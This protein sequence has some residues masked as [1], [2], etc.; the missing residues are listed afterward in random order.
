MRS[1]RLLVTLLAFAAAGVAQAQPVI[2]AD[3]GDSAW[4]LASIVLVLIGAL[5]GFAMI[6]NRGSG[7]APLA[8]LVAMAGA[9][10]LFT[11]FGYSLAFA[12]GSSMIGGA[13]NLLL[14]N[15]ADLRG[16]LT[17]SET[18][19][20]L[21]ELAAAL[22]AVAVL[23]AALAER[24]RF[25]WLACFAS[26][27]FVLVYV[28]LAHWLW[29]GGWLVDL[30]A[31]DAA[32]GLVIHT[33]AG[34][35]ALVAAI[36]LGRRDDDTLVADHRLAL[37][38]I[39][40]VFAGGVGLIGGS[41]LSSSDEAASAMLNAVVAVSAALLVGLGLER[42]RTGTTS[43]SSAAT[44]AI[45][46]LAAISCAGAAVAPGAA[47]MLGGLGAIGATLAALLV[48]RLSLGATASTFV[49]HA[50]GGI[51]GALAF[52]VFVLTALGGPGLEDGT[53]LLSLMTAQAV[54]VVV[55]VAWS[56]G[57]SA[58]AALMVAM[59]LPMRERRG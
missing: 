49:G 59:V 44:M 16:D 28:P 53:S 46:G 1:A 50:G 3:S 18:L 52:P 15:L 9:A 7:S 48:G 32:G 23:S 6:H 26:L 19:Y 41:G 42:L 43:T 51:I 22:F 13:D 57:L 8:P 29:G 10:V 40:L 30:G 12:P 36:L 25:G 5:S 55:V 20:A 11:L 56:A 54:A 17:I 27:W 39:G 58:I 31:A 14:A 2:V 47:V 45:A 34:V 35:S 37:A 4:V 24:A 21:F 38:G 33:A